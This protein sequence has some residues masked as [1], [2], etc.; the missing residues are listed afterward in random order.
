MDNAYFHWLVGFLDDEYIA[1]NYSKLLSALFNK[2]FT[3]SIEY[4][5]NRAADGLSLR[6]LFMQEY[7]ISRKT[8]DLWAFSGCS[9]LEMMLGMAK[10]CEDE[11]IYNPEKGNQTGQ[12]FWVMIENLGLDIYDDFG[13]YGDEVDRILNNFLSRN[14]APN[15]DGNLFRLRHFDPRK[16]DLWLQLNLYLRDHFYEYWG[17]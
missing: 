2:E 17:G 1:T 15:G 9:V 5:E 6:K 7:R 10:R 16:I 13:F 3:W 8:P 11:L 12:I 14:Y 4:D